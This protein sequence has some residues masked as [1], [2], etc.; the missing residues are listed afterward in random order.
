MVTRPELSVNNTIYDTLDERWY[1]AQDDPVALLRAEARSR[2]PW[3]LSEIRRT[4]GEGRLRVLDIGCGAGFLSNALARYGYA[5]TGIDASERSLVVAARHDD[6]GSVRYVRAD[7]CRLPSADSSF[8]VV[9]AMDFLEHVEDPEAIIAEAARVLTPGG[10][11]FFHTFNRTLLAWLVVIKGVEWFVRNTPSNL[12]V[13]SLFLKPSEVCAMC[14]SSSLIVRETRGFEPS[15]WSRAFLRLLMTG[16]VP[17]NLEFRFTRS[18]R[19]AYT[20]V[21]AKGGVSLARHEAVVPTP[22]GSGAW[23]TTPAVGD[24]RDD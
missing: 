7:A 9:C 15:I 2:T 20:G 11:F 10:L 12:H 13:L 18:T 14:D 4:F 6:T 5:V 21:A 3:V 16:T 8:E 1:A 19:I 17:E 24:G 23:P 22:R